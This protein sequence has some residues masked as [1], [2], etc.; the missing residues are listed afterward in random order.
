M[1]RVLKFGGTSLLV[2]AQREQGALRVR[3][4]LD[5]GI[6]PIVVVSAFGRGEPYS[7][8]T[9]LELAVR[10]YPGAA[11]HELALLGSC[12][13]TIA[14]AVFA[15]ALAHHGLA[16]VALTGAEAGVRTT[17]A[18]TDC[19]IATVRT[20]RLLHEL[21]AG[22]VPVVAGFQGRSP[23]GEVSLL[24]RGGS[25]VTAAAIAAH[26]GAESLEI[27]TDVPGV[28]SA[29]PRL[30]PSARLIEQLAYED[31]LSYADHGA[32]VVHP[33]AVR[34]AMSGAVPVR[35]CTAAG[36]RG[37]AIGAAPHAAAPGVPFGITARAVDGA[38]AE[39]AVVGCDGDELAAAV[40][41]VLRAADVDAVVRRERRAVIATVPA[42]AAARAA[43]LLH[44]VLVIRPKLPERL[45]PPVTAY[46]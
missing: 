46:A 29:D 31:A 37:S 8:Q 33:D 42:K 9:L 18:Y 28:M 36:S 30:V 41:R 17:G 32:Y 40:V 35:V 5:A 22:R 4:A 14:A 1:I 20:E 38:A 23:A 6:M 12:G 44:D 34:W 16:A 19:E 26:C 43:R 7:T 13:E 25:D 27:Y 15:C 45:A 3:E 24:K 11:E 21:I 39:V 10:A 2:P